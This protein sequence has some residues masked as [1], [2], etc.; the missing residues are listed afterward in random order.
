MTGLC[1]R[2]R[3][4]S[5]AIQRLDCFVPRNDKDGAVDDEGN[6]FPDRVGAVHNLSMEL[7][8][9][10]LV[11]EL[12]FDSTRGF[13]FVFATIVISD[14]EFGEIHRDLKRKMKTPPEPPLVRGG[15]YC[16]PLIRG[17]KGVSGELPS[18]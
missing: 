17:I 2:E 5:V 13:P 12:E 7:Y 1:H 9:V 4:T 6:A 8:E 18:S 10:R 14:E 11:V 16:L 3:G 15:A